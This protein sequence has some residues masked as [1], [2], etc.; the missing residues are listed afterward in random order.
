M[1]D[2]SAASKYVNVMIII[3]TAVLICAA[4]WHNK[5][6]YPMPSNQIYCQL[7]KMHK[8]MFFIQ[9]GFVYFTFTQTKHI[10]LMLYDIN[11]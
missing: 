5:S 7:N 3:I 9:H 6:S 11:K 2:I 8:S 4:V 1:A 10:T